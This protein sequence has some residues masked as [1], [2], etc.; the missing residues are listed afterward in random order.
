MIINTRVRGPV[1]DQ[2]LVIIDNYLDAIWM[3]KGL[4]QNT[5]SSYRRDLKQFAAFL[6]LKKQTLLAA[7]A[8][9]VFDYLGQNRGQGKS[10]RSTARLLSCLRGFYQYQLREAHITVNPTL[11]IDSPKLGRSP[12]AG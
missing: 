12:T 11:D 5:L 10:A 8:G 1:L 6:H 3:E 7:T 9:E 4:S 2:Q